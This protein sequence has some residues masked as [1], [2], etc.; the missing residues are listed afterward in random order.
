M[1]KNADEFLEDARS[2]FFDLALTGFDF[3]V[4]LLRNF[5]KKDHI[6]Y[7]SDFPFARANTV[8]QQTKFLDKSFSE[9]DEEEEFA[10]R[11]GAALR[12]FPRLAR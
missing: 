11:R 5:A 7:G 10:I 8:A 2:F 6:L 3:P 9:M 1:P 4:D 12:L